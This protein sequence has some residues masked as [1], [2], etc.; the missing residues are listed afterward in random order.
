MQRSYAIAIALLGVAAVAVPTTAQTAGRAAIVRANASATI[1]QPAM[2]SSSQDLMFA[3]SMST[4]TSLMTLSSTSTRQTSSGSGAARPASGA[5]SRANIASTL[6]Q[7]VPVPARAT[8]QV[9]GDA[10]QSISVTVP[11]AVGL[12]RVG[13]TGTATLTT[14]SSIADGPQFLGGNF[15]TAGTLSFDVGG[16]VTM[17]NASAPS[18]TYNGVLAV[19]AQYN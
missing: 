16:Q 13:G 1:Q 5:A 17:A 14:D 8:F 15:A 11:E 19:I 4:A 7:I 12:T 3:V 6:N 10:G 18:G 9:A 2:I